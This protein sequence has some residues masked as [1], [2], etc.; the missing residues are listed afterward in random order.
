MQVLSGM[1][2]YGCAA[3]CIGF[4]DNMFMAHLQGIVIIVF[5]GF[6]LLHL[7]KFHFRN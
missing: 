7:S 2:G 4:T 3:I 5:D 6:Y 1:A